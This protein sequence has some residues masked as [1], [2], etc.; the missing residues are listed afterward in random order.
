[1]KI[2]GINGRKFNDDILRDA[3]IATEQGRPI[4]LLVENADYLT[5]H[6][7]VYSGGLRYPHLNRTDGG[8]DLL[9]EIIK[10]RVH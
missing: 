9:A 7:L 5:S 6:R 4:E 2:I 10:P 8:P 1:M 3:L